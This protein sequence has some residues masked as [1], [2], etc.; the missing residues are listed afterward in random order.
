MADLTGWQDSGKKG[1]RAG[2]AAATAP[3]RT[4]ICISMANCGSDLEAC[5]H[6]CVYDGRADWL[7]AAQQP[8]K[9]GT[10]AGAAAAAAPAP[11]IRTPTRRT[12]SQRGPA[13]EGGFVH[14]GKPLWCLDPDGV[15]VQMQHQ[16]IALMTYEQ[17]RK[18]LSASDKYDAAYGSS[19]C[20]CSTLESAGVASNSIH[21]ACSW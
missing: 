18:E 4:P 5:L 7:A 10:R 11:P 16:D 12:R 19:P 13:A 15:P 14:V 9:K 3:T 6:R 1:T 8:G 17:L 21:R 2:A 20:A